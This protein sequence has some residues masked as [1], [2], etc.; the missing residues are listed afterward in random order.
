MLF[1]QPGRW[2]QRLLE[3]EGVRRT[4]KQL[5][6]PKPGSPGQVRLGPSPEYRDLSKLPPLGTCSLQLLR[7]A[8]LE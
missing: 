8:V 1:Q 2:D 3:L 4:Q 7:E 6:G 5:E